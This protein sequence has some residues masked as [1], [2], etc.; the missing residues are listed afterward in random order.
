VNT[1]TGEDEII[2]FK[3]K[4]NHKITDALFFKQNPA[5]DEF[6]AHVIRN[7]KTSPDGKALVFNAAGYIW[8]KSLPSGKPKRL[9]SGTDLEFEPSFAH[10]WK[11]RALR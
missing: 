4:A 1:E 3:A 5:P 6:K 7:T 11:I 9:T 8:V 10:R 2:P